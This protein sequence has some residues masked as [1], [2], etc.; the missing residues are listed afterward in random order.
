MLCAV[1]YVVMVI[2][3]IPIIL[4]L[5]YEP[6]DVVITMGRFLELSYP[7]ESK[8]TGVVLLVLLILI[9]CFLGALI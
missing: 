8:K 6:K 7:Q 1:A 4:F 5:K 2:G 9:S 3:R